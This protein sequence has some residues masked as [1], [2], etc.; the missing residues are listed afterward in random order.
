M[1]NITHHLPVVNSSHLIAPVKM[2]PTFQLAPELLEEIG[3]ESETHLRE[4]LSA[5]RTR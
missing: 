3:P 2:T 5:N 4:V 1:H